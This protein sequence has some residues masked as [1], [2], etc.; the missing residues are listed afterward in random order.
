[1][2]LLQKKIT[3][4][5]IL[6]M[7]GANFC[8]AQ[9]P[10]VKTTVSNNSILLGEQFQLKIEAVFAGADYRLNWINLP[11]S[12][13]HFE[14]IEKSKA[15]S[16]YNNNQLTGVTQIFTL[17]SFDSGKWN[18]PVAKIN[19]D[20]VKDDSTYNFF[21]DSLP[22]NVSFS[23]TDTTAQLRDIKPLYEVSDKWP[24]WY[25]IAGGLSTLI[26]A[27]LIVYLFRYWKK[28]KSTVGFK[29]KNAPFDEAMQQL[30]ALKKYN[31]SDAEVIKLFH[32]KLVIIFTEYLSA[33]YNTN[34][35]NKTTGDLLIVLKSMEV[36]AETVSKMASSLRCADAVKFAKYLPAPGDSENCLQVIKETIIRLHQKQTAKPV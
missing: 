36:W 17:T 20:P 8:W 26:L 28:N 16:V 11:D 12:L 3:L 34:H 35:L 24:L 2:K 32:L 10:I 4:F 29:S 31:L 6:L 5:L 15:D 23:V 18:L 30:D 14:L 19:I 33:N 21:S 27:A 9:L 22:I 25:W 13:Q 1:M 7:M